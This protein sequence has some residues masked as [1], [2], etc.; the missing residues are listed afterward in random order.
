M[1]LAGPRRYKICGLPIGL[2]YENLESWESVSNCLRLCQA[3]SIT[4][5]KAPGKEIWW[6][7]PLLGAPPTLESLF[8][9]SFLSF[10][11]CLLIKLVSVLTPITVHIFNHH[12][13]EWVNEGAKI[14]VQFWWLW[15][16]IPRD[17]WCKHNRPNRFCHTQQTCLNKRTFHKK[18]STDAIRKEIIF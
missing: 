1:S 13:Q 18:I 4:S 9:I 16:S 14:Q 7:F 10:P 12:W 11:L 2:A 17:P 5:K 3:S 8:H 15:V 6:L